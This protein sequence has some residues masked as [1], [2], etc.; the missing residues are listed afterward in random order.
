VILCALIGYWNTPKKLTTG[1]KIRQ[2]IFDNMAAEL[3]LRGQDFL[4]TCPVYLPSKYR[5]ADNSTQ[6]IRFDSLWASH[7]PQEI[8][9][10]NIQ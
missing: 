8:R 3:Q 2:I 10:K 1:T 6:P 4:G 5:H 9:E 7:Q